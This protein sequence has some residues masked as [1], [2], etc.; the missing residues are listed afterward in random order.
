MFTFRGYNYLQFIYL[1]FQSN[2]TIID[3]K[4]D[5]ICPACLNLLKESTIQL[6]VESLLKDD[7]LK[8][9]KCD[10][11]VCAI[12]FPIIL[13]L[14]Q[15]S[16][17]IGLITEFPGKI[18]TIESPDISVKEVFKYILNQRICTAT[19]KIFDPNGIMA[20]FYFEVENEDLELINLLDVKPGLFDENQKKR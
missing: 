7:R 18:S 13:N 3:D 15:L 4:N 10:T 12:Q 20:N 9:Y 19:N 11:I 2:L 17:W 8:T 16:I 14:R 5:T 6:T 1:Y